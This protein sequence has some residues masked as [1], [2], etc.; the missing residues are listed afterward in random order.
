MCI[1]WNM[2]GCF[3]DLWPKDNEYRATIELVKK[4]VT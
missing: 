1:F 3:Y 2:H 4:I